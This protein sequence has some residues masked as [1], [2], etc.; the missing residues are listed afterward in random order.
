MAA[1][2]TSPRSGRARLCGRIPAEQPRLGAGTQP[3]PSGLPTALFLLPWVFFWGGS[4]TRCLFGTLNAGH[5]NLCLE[6]AGHCKSPS[7]ACSFRCFP[8]AGGGSI[9]TVLSSLKDS[10]TAAGLGERRSL[11]GEA[12][13]SKWGVGRARL[14]L[15]AGKGLCLFSSRERTGV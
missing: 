6:D 10:L 1:L 12:G 14:C 11:V 9:L 8:A 13:V 3:S 4:T 2:V 5:L 15:V 7:P